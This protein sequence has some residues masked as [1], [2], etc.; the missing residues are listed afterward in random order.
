VGPEPDFSIELCPA[1][2]PK[3]VGRVILP[4]RAIERTI[5]H[6]IGGKMDHSRP[7]RGCM[8]A[9]RLDACY[10][11]LSGGS[12]LGFR[13]IDCRINC[14]VHDPG[15]FLPGGEILDSLGIGDINIPV[16]ANDI[17]ARPK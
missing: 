16:G 5:E 17:Q 12:R 15:D 9:E 11:G 7:G 13:L 2:D 14:T 8:P 10:I 6:V 3:W 1:I 4:I